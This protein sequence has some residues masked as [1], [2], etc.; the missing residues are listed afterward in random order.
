MSTLLLIRFVVVACFFWVFFFLIEFTLNK[1]LACIAQQ[2]TKKQLCSTLNAEIFPWGDKGE[3]DSFDSFYFILDLLNVE[4]CTSVLQRSKDK[5]MWKKG[6]HIYN[7]VSMTPIISSTLILHDKV[8]QQRHSGACGRSCW[9]FHFAGLIDV[10]LPVC[11]CCTGCR[12]FC[13]A[14]VDRQTHCN[15]FSQSGAAAAVGSFVCSF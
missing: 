1:C 12:I 5:N 9:R 14:S 13:T 8:S 11:A 3:N 10:Y 7:I 6:S 2:S 4:V 15:S